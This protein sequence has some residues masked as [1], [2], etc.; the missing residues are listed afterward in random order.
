MKIELKLQELLSQYDFI[1][2]VLIFGSFALD[3]Q[4]SMSDIDIAIQTTRDID[5]FTIG[6]IISNL[7]SA[8]AIKIDLVIL[9]NLY[10]KSPLLAYNIYQSHKQV[11]IND[12]EKYNDFKS[13]ALHYYLDFKPIIE[14]QNRAFLKR[15][16]NG[17]IAKTKTA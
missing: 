4:N 12:V 11:Y 8:L 3:K 9:N 5:I 13:N 2:N 15:V 7:E 14:E 6:E 16:E 1:S 10:K 17:T